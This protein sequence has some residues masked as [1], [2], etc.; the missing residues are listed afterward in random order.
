[1]EAKI[2]KNFVSFSTRSPNFKK[3]GHPRSE[4]AA[5][6]IRLFL[7]WRC[8]R[9]SQAHVVTAVGRGISFRAEGVPLPATVQI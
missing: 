4:V 7:L 1:M 8:V 6:S 2:H 9:H 3:N 5:L